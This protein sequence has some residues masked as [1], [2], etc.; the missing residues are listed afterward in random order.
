MVGKPSRNPHAPLTEKQQRFVEAY[1]LYQ[2]ATRAAIE[3]GY[4]KSG[5]HVLGSNLLKNPK[6]Q[7]E[8]KYSID[9]AIGRQHISQD[10]ILRELKRV[11]FGDPRAVVKFGPGG[12]ELTDSDSLSDDE[13]AMVAEVGETVTK[14]G[15]SKRIKMHD[16][17]KA[18]ELLGKH[19]SMWTDKTEITGRGGGPVELVAVARELTDE[20]LETI[21]AMARKREI[22]GLDEAVE[23]VSERVDEGK[24]QDVPDT[25][26]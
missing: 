7:S 24:E 21:A 19:M 22:A 12:V 6:I 25:E 16:K 8:I 23:A 13:A 20:E 17:L 4:A 18:L 26:G 1:A 10:M 5:A 9:R 3:A 2:N 15:G 14:E 11:A